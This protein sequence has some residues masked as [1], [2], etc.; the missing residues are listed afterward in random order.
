MAKHPSRKKKTDTSEGRSPGSGERH[1]QA[2]APTRPPAEP[3]PPG[4]AR[5]DTDP[6]RAVRDRLMADR[7]EMAARLRDLAISPDTDGD[8][9]RAGI[10]VGLDE[11]DQAQASER[12]DMVFATRE[13]LADRIGRLTHAIERIE[14]GTYGRCAEC[15]GLVEPER[16]AAMPEAETCLA[17]QAQRERQRGGTRAA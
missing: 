16:L 4:A 8:A 7:D 5:R 17:C 6:L 2:D 3:A 11:G 13:R 10:D 9:P 14:H 12:R 15:G 1:A